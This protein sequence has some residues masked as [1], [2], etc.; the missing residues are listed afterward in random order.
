MY[1]A[2]S[3]DGRSLAIDAQFA[4]KNDLYSAGTWLMDVDVPTVGIRTVLGN[5]QEAAFG[6]VAVRDVEPTLGGRNNFV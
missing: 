4:W 6:V 1:A 2:P 5:H 3:P